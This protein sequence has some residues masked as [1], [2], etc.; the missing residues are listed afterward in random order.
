[1]ADDLDGRIG[2]V[3][4]KIEELGIAD[5]TYVI[6]VADNGYRHEFLPGL[7]QPLH[8]RKWWVWEGGIR[9]P[10]IAMGPGIKGG[11]V[12][13]GNVVNYD[14]LPTFVDWAGGDPDELKDIDGVSLVPYMA[15]QEPDEEFLNRNLYFHY[16]HY[17]ATMPHTAMISG[18]HKVLHFYEHPDIRMLF[19]LSKDIGEVHNI[20]EEYPMKHQKLFDEM[21][22]YLEEVGG[23]I[24]KPNP[25]YDPEKYRAAQRYWDRIN[26]GPFTGERPLDDDE[27]APLLRSIRRRPSPGTRKGTIRRSVLETLRMV[28]IFRREPSFG[29]RWT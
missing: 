13:T 10:M 19:D 18:S 24:P 8:A 6:M 11:S 25:D 29:S 5:N 2:A 22:G 1:M 21:M 17:R 4:D 15:G 12:F 7:T 16:P 9:V 20:A 26:W 23:R 27:R 3:L 14:L 28:R